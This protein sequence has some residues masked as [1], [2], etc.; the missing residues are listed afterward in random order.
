MRGMRNIQFHSYKGSTNK[1]KLSSVPVLGTRSSGRAICPGMLLVQATA[2]SNTD[3]DGYQTADGTGSASRKVLGLCEYLGSRYRGTKL[4]SNYIAADGYGIAYYIK[5]DDDLVLRAFEDGVSSDIDSLSDY[6]TGLMGIVQGTISPGATS[7]DTNYPEQFPN[8][9]LDSSD[10]HASDSKVA[11]L[12]GM[13][14]TQDNYTKARVATGTAVLSSD[15][16]GSVTINDGGFG[17]TQTPLIAFSGGGGSGAAATATITDGVVTAVT[18]SN[19]GSSYETVPT[20]TFTQP[21]RSLL[22]KITAAYR[23]F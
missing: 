9:L 19:N 7:T 21:A 14:P 1:P 17:Y 10:Y 20:V 6:D 12:L 18:M 23:A 5:A 8:D 15:T 22:F 2:G 13:E 4:D 11:T 16:V 3:A